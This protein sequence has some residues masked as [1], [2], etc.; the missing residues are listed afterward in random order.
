M[1]NSSAF[2]ATET[3]A[4]APLEWL[5]AKQEAFD[6][7]F[8][9]VEKA[10]P[11]IGPF[12]LSDLVLSC[13]LL[14][15]LVWQIT[16]RTSFLRPDTMQNYMELYFPVQESVYLRDILR[17]LH[18]EPRCIVVRFAK[19]LFEVMDARLDVLEVSAA[20]PTRGCEYS[21]G[22]AGKYV[23]PNIVYLGVWEINR[24]PGDSP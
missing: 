20:T 13:Q 1:T 9:L 15:L 19:K 16:T 23:L 6:Q 10:Y 18:R 8:K 24:Y 12:H 7:Q 5:V 17:E 4:T 22:M 21:E 14:R 3:E 2:G 11:F